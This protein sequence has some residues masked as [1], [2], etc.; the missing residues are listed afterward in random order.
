MRSNNLICILFISLVLASC[1]GCLEESKS[2]PS[3]A[4]LSVPRAN[5]PEGFT[6]LAA[7]PE[8]DPSVN[9]TDYIVEFSGP[10][11][12]GPA[13]N[14]SVGIYRWGVPGDSYDAKIIQIQLSDEEHADGAVSNFKMQE[15]YQEQLAR[16][17]SIF[18][19]ATV[20]GH[21]TLEI[22]DIRGDNS[23]RYLYLWNVGS[24]VALVE[25]NHDRSKSL[26]LA[27]ATGL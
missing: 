10:Q 22:K 27:S 2:V 23:I 11:D 19:N 5:L 3:D 17:I 16:G 8:N 15:E 20:N 14:I 7:L 21:P 4:D 6:L 1:A 9:M 24:I 12:I 13:N 25:G 18:G 26:E